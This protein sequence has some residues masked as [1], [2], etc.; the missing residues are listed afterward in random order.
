M[1]LLVVLVAFSTIKS[2]TASN[3]SAD[4]QK[5]QAVVA[6]CTSEFLAKTIRA[7]NERTTYATDQ[8]AANIE[9]QRAQAQFVGIVLTDPPLPSDAQRRALQRYY[10]ALNDYIDV[11]S[12][13]SQKAVQFPYPTN[14][15]YRACL[16]I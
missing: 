5:N 6:T 8:A 11:N 10:S 1:F 7:L 9:L 12:K 13:V 14:D 3:R 2:Q 15:E 16:G 4:V